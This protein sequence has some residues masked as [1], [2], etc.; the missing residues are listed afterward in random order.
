V[1]LPERERHIDRQLAAASAVVVRLNNAS[2]DLVVR[3]IRAE[4]SCAREDLGKPSCIAMGSG[5]G[6]GSVGA[7]SAS[8]ARQNGT[9]AVARFQERGH[10]PIFAV[11]FTLPCAREIPS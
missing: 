6:T 1:V 11:H 8:S 7:E 5:G 2:P 3:K 9:R 10:L 4:A